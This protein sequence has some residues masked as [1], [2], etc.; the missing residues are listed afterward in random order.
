MLTL[1]DAA[2][3][4]RIPRLTAATR[5]LE[6]QRDSAHHRLPLKVGRNEAGNSM[7]IHAPS[8]TIFWIA[9]AL[10]FLALFGEFV[11]DMGFLNLYNFWISVAASAVLILGCIV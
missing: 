10:L 2:L 5:R 6:N 4:R 1:C 11:P 8:E 3:Q 7:K 9:G